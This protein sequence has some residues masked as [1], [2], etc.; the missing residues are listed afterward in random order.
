M[1]GIVV[2][3]AVLAC[4]IPGDKPNIIVVL[5][6]DQR[7]DTITPEIMPELNRR[8]IDHGIL[9]T[10]AFITNP[11]C[12]PSRAAI[13]SGGYYSH[14]TQILTNSF[15]N[16]SAARFVDTKTIAVLAQQQGYATCFVGKYL[17]F[18]EEVT[19]ISPDGQPIE[20]RH[21]T[22]PAWDLF[23]SEISARLWYKYKFIFGSSQ[24]DG[25][26]R[27]L[28]LPLEVN[29]LPGFLN[30]PEFRSRIQQYFGQLNF[31][32]LPY[33]AH[34]HKDVATNF[35]LDAAD[36]NQPF[37]VF[38]ASRAP[39]AP[40]TPE[41]QYENLFP[42]FEY[43]DRGWGEED[44]DDKPYYVRKRAEYFENAYEGED[45]FDD[46][47]A[48]QLRTLRSIDDMIASLSD[49]IDSDERLRNTW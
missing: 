37:L 23:E 26:Q 13:L 29:D 49:L 43:R 20:K 1:C 34:F 17:N 11:L 15:E 9:Y 28:F 18:L 19:G 44:L 35:I 47:T 40:A 24:T 14:E 39:H 12:C 21:Y 8:L 38:I 10:N 2:L 16:G 41:P 3:F 7:W 22:P 42:G 45:N 33:I 48:N 36:N 32:N 4:Q 6:D 46:F 25:P 27:G 5:T 31:G 30:R